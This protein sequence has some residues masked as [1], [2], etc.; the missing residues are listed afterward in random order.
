MTIPQEHEVWA[1]LVLAECLREAN[2]DVDA[3][4]EA[5]EYILS[6]E[7]PSSAPI[8]TVG[9]TNIIDASAGPGHDYPRNNSNQ[10]L[11]K[12]A[13]VE[14]ARNDLKYKEL[15]ESIPEEHRWKLDRAIITL[16]GGGTINHPHEDP[17]AGIDLEGRV[18]DEEWAKYEEEAQA[19]IEWE[20]RDAERAE[21]RKLADRATKILRSD[22]QD[23]RKINSILK[24]AGATAA[25]IRLMGR[26]RHDLKKGNVTQKSLDR[27]YETIIERI[28]SRI[29]KAGAS[30]P[31]PIRS[32]DPALSVAL[33]REDSRG[34]EHRGKGSPRGG[35]FVQHGMGE[36]DV[37][38]AVD[39]DNPGAEERE[40]QELDNPL[41]QD[42]S[43][44]SDIKR[45]RDEIRKAMEEQDAIDAVASSVTEGNYTP[46]DMQ[47]LSSITQ[48]YSEDQRG[49]VDDLTT[50][51][52]SRAD[53]LGGEHANAAS[54]VSFE[55]GNMGVFKDSLGEA[56]NLRPSIPKGTYYKREVA[57]ALVGNILGMAD[58]VP[59][60]VPRKSG[61]SW[62]S[63]QAFVDNAQTAYKYGDEKDRFDGPEDAARAALFDYIVGSTDRHANNWMLQGGVPKAEVFHDA[64]P[65]ERGDEIEADDFNLDNFQEDE[66]I[67]QTGPPSPVVKIPPEGVEGLEQQS[68]GPKL[69]LIDNGLSFPSKHSPIEM[70]NNQILIHA[71][72]NEL[73]MPDVSQMRD[74]WPKIQTALERCGVEPQAI[75]LAKKRFDS[76]TSGKAKTIGDLDNIYGAGYNSGKTMR[77]H[78][79]YYGLIDARPRS[80]DLKKPLLDIDDVDIEPIKQRVQEHVDIHGPADEDEIWEMVQEFYRDADRVPNVDKVVKKIIRLMRAAKGKGKKG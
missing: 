12:L 23:L 30:D 34:V 77:D 49:V 47:L 40:P 18:A 14:A 78:Y 74:K 9:D 37:E 38:E 69:A 2:G 70:R 17:R 7:T 62:G 57:A 21:L 76:A 65:G 53:L 16:V 64:L 67:P 52:I 13:I 6:T 8:A 28:H 66:D 54:L 50:T 36:E 79:S 25:E 60:T 1:C 15:R 33:A 35:Q 3:G 41:E 11:S 31:E 26:L 71:V 48:L 32:Q 5:A 22:E 58:L 42:G 29:D 55:S 68:G 75:A 45:A 20:Q 61:D 56:D 19:R 73:P 39:F 46:E 27:Q 43:E 59:V 80:I 4:F 63:M 72:N 24:R 44:D 10:F 51:P